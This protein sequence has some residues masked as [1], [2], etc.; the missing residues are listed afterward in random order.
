MLAKWVW[1]CFSLNLIVSLG[2]FELLALYVF[3]I[4]LV[5][6]KRSSPSTVLSYYIVMLTALPSKV[7][8]DISGVFDINHLAIINYLRLLS[9]FILLP[10][11]IKH[12]RKN[13]SGGKF[14]LKSNLD[15]VFVI[16]LLL[17]VVLSFR[18]ETFTSS[19]REVF[20]ISLHVALPYY[21]FKNYIIK[22]DDFTD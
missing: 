21:V 16:W 11:L 20:Y 2:S 17:I 7:G 12:F 18:A 15:K 10:L 5:L 3:F 4:Y 9:I 6:L 22:R 13:Y 1:L 8:Y 19:I 14:K